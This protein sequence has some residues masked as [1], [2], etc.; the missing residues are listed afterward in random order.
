[1]GKK[2]TREMT[3]EEIVMLAVNLEAWAINGE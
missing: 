1:M 3:D 2:S